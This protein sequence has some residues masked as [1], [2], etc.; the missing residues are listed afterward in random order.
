M[1]IGNVKM[2]RL[3]HLGKFSVF[4]NIFFF[5][6]LPFLSAIFYRAKQEV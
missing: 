2:G 1:H 6:A 3:V 5:S 4:Y